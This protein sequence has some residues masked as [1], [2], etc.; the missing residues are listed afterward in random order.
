MDHQLTMLPAP[1]R[2]YLISSTAGRGPCDLCGAVAELHQV[3]EESRAGARLLDACLG[4]AGRPAR[5][6]FVLARAA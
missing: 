3:R 4:C 6:I 5:P 2:L 1:R